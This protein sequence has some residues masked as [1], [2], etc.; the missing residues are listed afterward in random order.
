[1]TLE[2]VTKLG[3]SSLIKNFECVP[4]MKQFQKSCVDFECKRFCI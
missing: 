3:A 2:K 4:D 1:M